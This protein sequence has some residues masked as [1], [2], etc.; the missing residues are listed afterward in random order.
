[1]RVTVTVMGT[2]RGRLPSDHG[3]ATV[4]VGPEGTVADA[5]RAI[6]MADDE[7]WNA[8]ISGQ[9]VGP[10][11]VLR[12]GD[13]LLVFTPIVGGSKPSGRSQDERGG[14]HARSCRQDPAG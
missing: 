1:M 5:L 10:D 4:E 7:Q 2:F 8:S 3:P 9:L 12:E 11:H 6:G 13:A 14:R